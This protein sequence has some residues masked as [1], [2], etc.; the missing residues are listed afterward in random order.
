MPNA[1]KLLPQWLVEVIRGAPRPV[2][3][4]DSTRPFLVIGH[5]G[6][7]CFEV[8]NTLASFRRA[9]EQDGAN[10]LEFD[11][12]FTR[13]EQLVLWHDWDPDAPLV[14]LREAGLEPGVYARPCPPEDGPFRR[15]LCELTLAE[16]CGHFS[17][18]AKDGEQQYRACMPRLE[19][20]LAW[21]V[22]RPEVIVLFCD[23]KVPAE[24]LDLVP[25]M[26]ERM[27][28]LLTRYRPSATCIFECADVAVS[29][30]MQ[31]HSPQ[32]PY[33]LMGLR[34]F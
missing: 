7:P 8:E 31:A 15:P 33:S 13:D 9:V 29:A 14:R 22:G 6:A 12:C 3:R 32:H 4:R 28:G 1:L 26:M 19:E 21:V 23:M 24:R 34:L 18:R 17:Y 27:N 20:V 30:A 10:R 11:L 5:R 2:G 16:C 25:V